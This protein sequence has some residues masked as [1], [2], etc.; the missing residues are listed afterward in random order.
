MRRL[1]ALSALLT[2]TC[3]SSV[4]PNKG[5]YSCTPA[6]GAADC[7][8][9]YECKVQRT[10]GAFC[11]KTGTCVAETCNGLDDDCNGVA[12]DSFPN[13]D[14]A[15][16]TAAPGVCGMGK[17]FCVDAGEVCIAAADAGT[18][19]CNGLDD[20]CDGMTDEAF[21]LATDDSNCGACGKVCPPGTNCASG[22]CRETNCGDDVDNDG[23]G[24]TDCADPNCQQR[25]CFTSADAG[26]VC[27]VFLVPDAG[28]IDAGVDAGLD[29]GTD[30]G[31]LDAGLDA[32]D[33]DAGNLD[34]GV[35]DAGDPDAGS[36][37]GVDAGTDGG[38]FFCFPAEVCD[39]GAD[40]DFDHLTDCADPDCN[41]RTCAS[42]TVCT[43]GLC[44]GPG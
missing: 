20:D 34:A 21:F 5:K 6:T 1:A 4:D 31:D 15:C 9:G 37:A 30:A 16:T 27:G 39:D 23:D 19:L 18:E 26:F 14:K 24:G 36:D 29:A 3:L 25:P 32:G 7:G 41:G 11:F 40:N 42:G 35:P 13:A 33:L 10:G 2:I 8:D 17:L 22:R 44:P 28:A 43:N 38:R 12:D